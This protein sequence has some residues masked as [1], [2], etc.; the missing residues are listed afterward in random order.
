MLKYIISSFFL[1][2]FFAGIAQN[3]SID[4]QPKDTVA[5]K[6]PYGLRV[7]VDLS[8]IIQSSL[9]DDYS[10]LELVA[11]Y[12]L[13]HKLYVAAELGTEENT[14]QEDLY[15]FTSSGNYIKLGVDI[16][17]YENWYGMNN[18]IYM[19]GRIA[20]SRF[21]QT[22]NDYQIFNSNR[23]WSPDDFAIGST[24]AREISDLSATWLEFVFGIKTELFA[25][26]FLGGSVRLGYLV[27]NSIDEKADNF[28]N[29]WIPGFN[30]VTEGS[31]FGIGYNYSISYL[32]PLYKKVKKE[33][34]IKEVTTP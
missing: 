16:N 9:K 31:K 11:D 4:L 3:K 30:K 22:I 14:R 20:Y 24:D 18:S 1:C 5:Y 7:G 2:S 13:T 17:N 29:I 32:I 8:R 10:G 26:I 23:Y 27:N 25:N 6:Q 21:S 33:K 19:G 28:K 15:N 34:E 12:R